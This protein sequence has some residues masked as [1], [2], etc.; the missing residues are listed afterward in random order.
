MRESIP[1]ISAWLAIIIIFVLL[2]LSAVSCS[3]EKTSDGIKEDGTIEIDTKYF[4][5]REFIIDDA[6]QIY[7]FSYDSCLYM[8]PLTNPVI[9]HLPTCPNTKNHTHNCK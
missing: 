7:V 3:T 4:L 8:M 6:R 5:V 1:I 9:L 2:M